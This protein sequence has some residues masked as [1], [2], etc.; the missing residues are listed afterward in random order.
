MGKEKLKRGQTA[1]EQLR[2]CNP[3]LTSCRKYLDFEQPET[4]LLG[5]EPAESDEM[6]SCLSMSEFTL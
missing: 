3:T 1:L 2:Q 5:R 6:T 4:I